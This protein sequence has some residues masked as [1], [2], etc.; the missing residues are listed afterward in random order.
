MTLPYI[1]NI[2]NNLLVFDKN[3]RFSRNVFTTLSPKYFYCDFLFPSVQRGDHVEGRGDNDKGGRG[4]I[5][6]GNYDQLLFYCGSDRVTKWTANLPPPPR[7]PVSMLFW[8]SF[9]FS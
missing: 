7:Q 6:L 5:K 9:K 8:V 2:T 3:L 4:A 1:F